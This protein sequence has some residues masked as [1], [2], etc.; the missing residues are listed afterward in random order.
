MQPNADDAITA[1]LRQLAQRRVNS[2]TLSLALS[3]MALRRVIDPNYRSN[4]EGDLVL[5]NL[6]NLANIFEG[7]PLYSGSILRAIGGVSADEGDAGGGG[8][9]R[10]G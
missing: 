5:A 7:G 3:A 8:I 2:E 10:T 4:S 1:H 9:E 6:N